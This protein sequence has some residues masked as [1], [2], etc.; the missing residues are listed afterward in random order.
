MSHFSEVQRR[1]STSIQVM[2]EVSKPTKA[3]NQPPRLEIMLR[4]G[5][6]ETQQSH[7]HMSQRSP[8]AI[9]DS[10]FPAP[11]RNIYTANKGTTSGSEATVVAN[12]DSPTRHRQLQVQSSDFRSLVEPRDQAKRDAS[13]LA[14][15]VHHYSELRLN[16]F[17]TYVV[18]NRLRVDDGMTR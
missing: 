4:G 7:S 8:S 6:T 5:K 3:V 10:D 9:K 12:M 13:F 11:T 17:H 2:M 18:L 16:T 14:S 15:R 1:N